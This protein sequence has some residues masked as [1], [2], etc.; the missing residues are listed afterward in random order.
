MPFANFSLNKKAKKSNPLW[1]GDF[2][3][4]IR[5]FSIWL[6]FVVTALIL[7]LGFELV[8]SIVEESGFSS[9]KVF[10]YEEEEGRIEGEFLGRKFSADI[11]PVLSVLP[12][13]DNI[14]LLLP[15]YTGLF[16]RGI[17]FLLQL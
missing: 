7:V 13:A 14:L 4:Y 11:S 17:A 16:L 8:N 5:I 15:P 1:G 10:A 9:G 3:R 6:I 12:Y 2:L